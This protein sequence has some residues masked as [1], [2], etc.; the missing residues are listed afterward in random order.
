[1]SAWSPSSTADYD[2]TVSL[3]GISDPTPSDTGHR[4]FDPSYPVIAPATGFGHQ[5][6]DVA[7]PGKGIPMSF[8]RYYHSGS[9]V[10]RSMGLGWTHSYDVYLDVQSE[11][12]EVHYPQGHSST[13]SFDPDGDLFPVSGITDELV[14]HVDDTLTLTTKGQ[15]R[16]E[17]DA[18]GV[19]RSIRDRNAVE[20]ELFYD[21]NGDLDYIED[22]GGRKLEFTIDGNGR[23]TK[24]DLPLT[25]S[26]EY[27]YNGSGEL[28]TFTDLLAGETDYA[29]GTYGMTS[30]TDPKNN[31]AV[32][33]GYDT[34]GRLREQ[35][36][37]LSKSTCTYYGYGASYSSTACTAITP[38]ATADEVVV[39]DAEGNAA[40]FGWGALLR[41]TTIEDAL[42]GVTTNV[43]DSL[44][45]VT[46]VN[47][48]LNQTTSFTYDQ[49]R[50]VL[51]QTDALSQVWTYTYNSFNDV[52][53]AKDPRNKTTTYAYDVDGNLTSVTDAA[54]NATTF[55]VDADGLVTK[56]TDAR[57]N[58]T[59][60]TY[61]TYG[62]R[63]T[64]TNQLDDV[65]TY[66]YDAGS[67]LTEVEDPLTHAVDYTYNNA[68]QVLTATNELSEVTTNAYDA[69]GNL[70]SV[71]DAESNATTYTYDA[72][73]RLTEITDDL[74][75]D[76]T[77]A[78]DDVGNQTSVTNVRGKVTSYVYDDLYRR[79]KV[80]DPL[81]R[82]TEYAYDAIGNQ[83]ERTDARDLVTTYEYDAVNQLT[84]VNYVTLFDVE[85]LVGD[86]GA[87]LELHWRLGET[88]GTVADDE[89]TNGRDGT[90]GANVT[91]G[92][93]GAVGYDADP[94]M[95][96]DGTADSNVSLAS[97]NGMPTGAQAR[98]VGVWIRTDQT[99]TTT[100]GIW[101][102]GTNGATR[103]SFNLR[104]DS[105]GNDRLRFYAWADDHTFYLPN[106]GNFADGDWHFVVVT[107]DGSTTVR[108]YFDG[109]EA[110]SVKTLG[111]ALNTGDA[112]TYVGQTTNDERW[113][114]DLDDFFVVDRALTSAEIIRFIYGFES[115]T[116][117]SGADD[118]FIKDS[119]F[120]STSSDLYVG[121][122]SA[123]EVHH[124]YLRFADVD[125]P[126][127]ASIV[128]STFRILGRD[129]KGWSSYTDIV[130]YDTDDA[131]QLT[132]TAEFNTAIAGQTTAAAGIDDVYGYGCG[133]CDTWIAREVGSIVSEIV[134]RGGWS[135]G[136]A[137]AVLLLDD[138]GNSNGESLKVAAQEN[139]GGGAAG[140][141]AAQLDITYSTAGSVDYEYD[142]A[143][144]R[145][146]MTDSTGVTT[147]TY[148]SLN[149]VTNVTFP[150]ADEFDYT[151]DANGNRTQIAYPDTKDVDYVY[152]AANQLS[153]VTDWLSNVTTYTYD[154]AGRLTKSA[155]PTGAEA[156]Y[157]YDDADRLLTVLNKKGAVTISTHTY[158]LD[159]VGNRT[160]VVD[161][162]GTTTYA[163]DD[164]YRLTSVTYPGPSTDT[165]T[166]DALGNRLTKNTD[167]YTYDNADQLTDVE[168][169]TYSYDDNGNLTARG[170][171]TFTWDRENRML[172]ADVGGNI[173]TFTYNADGVR[174]QQNNEGGTIDYEVDVIAP[175]PL[176]M[177]DD[178][179]SYVYG[180]DLISA[181]D[182]SA[183][184][185]YYLYDGLGSVAALTD[186]SGV[187]TDSYVY[188][189]FGAVTSS[190]GTTSN[191]WLFTGEQRD[192]DTELYFLRARYY[193][194]EIGR[195]LAR[196]PL[197]FAQRYAYAGNN[198]VA[199]TDPSGL[200][201][202]GSIT[203]G[204]WG[205]VGVAGAAA[206]ADWCSLDACVDDAGG[207]IAE[208]VVG[209]FGT[210][211]NLAVGG[212]IWIADQGQ[213][214][215]E[216]VLDQT[217][218][219]GGDIVAGWGKLTTVFSG[220]DAE[221]VNRGN[222]EAVPHSWFGPNQEHE[223]KIE[224]LEGMGAN[225]SHFNIYRDKTDGKL[226]LVERNGD[227]LIPT[228]FTV[229]DLP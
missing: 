108:L 35:T 209:A 213:S 219:L 191:D 184:E 142:A 56:V 30:I 75:Q 5:Q 156:T 40:R 208:W 117:A 55:T 83:I 9:A 71:T 122:G 44:N 113:V 180:L 3:V 218:D 170:S 202:E 216:W 128:G 175:L 203:G 136:N 111:A 85:T 4:A 185:V 168:G 69:N 215:G 15:V 187:E 164:L 138:P 160:Q 86:F 39:V 127:G 200:E 155:Y 79:T 129:A 172:K 22:A 225:P 36:N 181:V 34:D 54:T 173:A 95:T 119:T 227:G 66:T 154:D 110:T 140:D 112:T 53:T 159:D 148:D 201:Y 115:V 31:V 131:P 28:T 21:I 41:T 141:W 120:N 104:R 52:L 144:N 207:Q 43:F 23:I 50:N 157:T 116:V 192:G 72:A 143:G 222:L 149:R 167:D 166:Y 25:R 10:D 121:K 12:V 62:N 60:Y 210:T 182:G 77:Y 224:E 146:E 145:T 223:I 162:Q 17:F 176:V 59:D 102:F 61:D 177:Q 11:S 82:V 205:A 24:I 101:G 212:A 88:S 137:M 8:S 89:S 150:D 195:F 2:T 20:T 42:G 80:T 179:Y 63:A 198:P 114:G 153:T 92:A 13:F 206:Y 183:N 178:E 7:I 51:T 27:A 204:G 47:N 49:D 33:N 134:T 64:V 45:N 169:T 221:E 220:G 58:E 107:Y 193:D 194:P 19:L 132:S 90:I 26:V 91:L 76:T 18:D 130:G 105:G 229:D 65:W 196:D 189:A 139:T 98:S 38:A 37:A 14:Q 106:S 126:Q 109:L 190:T 84:K 67:R 73:N 228:R 123:G 152:D 96:F 188:D 118:A 6:T 103:E 16:Y 186:D 133:I 48:P 199:Y 46:S 158:T 125:V 147:Y 214:G 174:V 135:S 124:T 68:D 87:D 197:E 93:D 97:G 163:Y 32:T 57:S 99:S 226:Y 161:D 217:T 165:Y 151:Y 74:S 29:Y 70:T 94:A 78:Y 81:S 171:D 100:A 211:R 1:L